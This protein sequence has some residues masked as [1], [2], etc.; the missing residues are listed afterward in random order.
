MVVY[1]DSLHHVPISEIPIAFKEAARVSKE[2][3]VLME[4]NDSGL[5]LLLENIGF[6]TSIERSGNYVFRFKKSLIDYWCK[7]NNLEFLVYDTYFDKREHRPN[8]YRKPFIGPLAY[9]GQNLIGKMLKSFGNEAL[10][11]LK[12]NI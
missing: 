5:R 6:S 2:Y 9:Y 12:K 3:V 1:H 11:I 10:I 8:F 7:R 4:A